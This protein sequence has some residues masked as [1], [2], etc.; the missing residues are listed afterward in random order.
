MKKLIAI[1]MSAMMALTII[2]A[3]HNSNKTVYGAEAE[4]EEITK[5]DAKTLG[6]FY[7]AI[8]GY[9]SGSL[10]YLD[11]DTTTKYTATVE[12]DYDKYSDLLDALNT[13]KE[14]AF[15][16]AYYETYEDYFIKG[17]EYDITDIEEITNIITGAANAETVHDAAVTLAEKSGELYA[18]IDYAQGLACAPELALGRYETEK[19]L[20]Q[21]FYLNKFEPDLVNQFEETFRET[22]PQAYEDAFVALT[23][24]FVES[25]INFTPIDNFNTEFS[26]VL[27]PEVTGSTVNI[28]FPTGSVLG[29]GYIGGYKE[30]KPLSYDTS[31]FE[32]VDYDFYIDAYNIN[33]FNRQEYIHS[34][35][36]FTMSVDHNLVSDNIGI[37]EYKNGAWQYLLT[38]ISADSVSHTFPDGDYYGGRYCLFVEPNYK[39]FGDIYFSPFYDEIYTYAR[40]GVLYDTD[41]KYDPTSYITRGDLA[42][43]INGVLNPNNLN[44]TTNTSFTDVPTSSPYYIA[45]NFVSSKGY[46]N[47]VSSTSFGVNDKITYNQLQTIISRMTGEYFNINA[48]FTDMKN[49]RF[50]KSKGLTDMNAYVTKEEAVYIIYSVLQ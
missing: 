8:D 46:I 45:S 41:T 43:M 22:F 17:Q 12:E 26:F 29:Y 11:G 42:Y 1:T 16:T 20:T 13:E 33:N 40:R 30:K 28:T 6:S 25:N 10:Y 14:E 44:Y 18:Q 35:K 39:T 4:T 21:R 5:E 3:N 36:D 50:Y 23:L 32:F 2:P 48:V 7:G 31:R 49:D 9:N 34:Y 15:E 37:Y 24:D 27:N 38:D 19:S 47:G